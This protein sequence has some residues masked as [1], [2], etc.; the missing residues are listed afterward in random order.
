MPNGVIQVPSVARFVQ[1]TSA[2]IPCAPSAK[3]IKEW[4]T[5]IVCQYVIDRV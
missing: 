5:K 3:E 2:Q 4:E 1:M